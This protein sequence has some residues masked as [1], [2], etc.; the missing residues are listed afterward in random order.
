MKTITL[1]HKRE[2]DNYL[3]H[4]NVF[5]NGEYI[6]YFMKASKYSAKRVNW[7]FVSNHDSVEYFVAETKNEVLETI[8]KQVNHEHV[9]LK[10]HF[11]ITTELN[12]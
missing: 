6:G 10:Q 3:A 9:I 5:V 11:S 7:N 8:E 1:K 12:K 2:T 4:T